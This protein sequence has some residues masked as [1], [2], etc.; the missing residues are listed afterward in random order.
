[1]IGAVSDDTGDDVIRLDTV[2]KA[3][4][5]PVIELAKAL[6]EADLGAVVELRS[7]DAAAKVDI[8]VWCRMQRQT[9]R[10]QR[11]DAGVWTFEV[12]KTTA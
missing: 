3:C 5:F 10:A 11:E 1:M 4:P 6:R 2:G 12:E 7:D 8:P 9:L